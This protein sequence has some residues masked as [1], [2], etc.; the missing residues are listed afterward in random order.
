LSTST[1]PRRVRT[2]SH[3]EIA[4]VL[5]CQAK[6]DFSYVGA[7]AGSALKPKTTAPLLRDGRAWGAAVAAYH[8]DGYEAALGALVDSLEEDAEEQRTAGLYLP[9]E[10]EEL[11]ERLTEM[12][13]H[14]STLT[15]PLALTRLEHE[16]LVPIPSRTGLRR[17]SAYRLLCKLDGIH[18]DEDG[19]TWI[20]EF[21]LR[22]QLSPFEQISLS[23]QTRWYA[24]AWQEVTGT[25]PA[26]VITEERLKAIP[27]PVKINQ[28]GSPS[29]VQT[30]TPEAYLAAFEGRPKRP[31]EDVLAALRAKVWQHRHPVLFRPEEIEEAGR[32]MVSA[33]AQVQ[34][35]DSG[36]LYPIRNPSVM[37]CP[38]CAFQSICGQPSDTELVDALFN[39]VPPKAERNLEVAA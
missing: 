20:V 7:L 35:F 11:R 1:L 28:D 6:H 29:R 23:R 30:C 24:W 33:A 12:L 3:S 34:Q 38:G 36:A 31:D 2:I 37:R 22:G 9:S 18:V 15:E 4:S 19:R 39:R 32:Q 10:H 8:A 13:E 21:K 5:D 16:L 17:S 25:A 27:K 14:Y 26:G